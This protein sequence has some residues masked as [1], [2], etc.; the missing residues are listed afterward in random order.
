MSLSI[1]CHP[2]P[3]NC[4]CTRRLWWR[5]TF[6]DAGLAVI[7]ICHHR[8]CTWYKSGSNYCL[9]PFF[10][11]N[12]IPEVS[13]SD[14][15]R[16]SGSEHR[17]TL[18]LGL[19]YLEGYIEWLVLSII[20]SVSHKCQPVH[21]QAALVISYYSYVVIEGTTPGVGW[22]K[23]LL[24]S[25]ED[26]VHPNSIANG[27]VQ[28]ARDPLHIATFGL[29]FPILLNWVKFRPGIWDGGAIS[30]TGRGATDSSPTQGCLGLAPSRLSKQWGDGHFTNISVETGV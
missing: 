28:T 17:G 3:A 1:S 20:L 21:I 19:P 10:P 2:A 23:E 8:L 24:L 16:N 5:V 22:G 9:G 12:I 15:D 11:W 26:G 6:D 14:V 30:S 25:V 29:K 13:G 27:L 18:H 4:S 7:R